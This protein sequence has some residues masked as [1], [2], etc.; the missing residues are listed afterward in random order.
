MWEARK[1]KDLEEV[2]GKYRLVVLKTKSF[3][4]DARGRKFIELGTHTKK[5]FLAWLEE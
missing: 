3:S 2:E 1:M 4:V 5:I